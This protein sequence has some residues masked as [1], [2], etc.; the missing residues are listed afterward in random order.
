MRVAPAE[1]VVALIALGFAG[2]PPC[3]ATVLEPEPPP[4]ET[5]EYA[6]VA[7]SAVLA[8]LNLGFGVQGAPNVLLGALGIAVGAGTV[9]WSM[10]DG[11]AHSTALAASGGISMAM[12]L[13]A[14]GW[15]RALD[16]EPAPSRIAPAWL[17]SPSGGGPGI[18]LVV[19]F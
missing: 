5:A 1:C 11:V 19:D 6:A 7:A 15:R 10:G 17:G 8:G 9:V 2:V 12:G 18:L 16:R 13:V 14:V 4:H 3:R